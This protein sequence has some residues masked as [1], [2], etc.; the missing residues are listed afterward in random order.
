MLQKQV[1]TN[2]AVDTA[3]VT[4]TAQKED[5]ATILRNLRIATKN[6]INRVTTLETELKRVDSTQ[7]SI[8]KMLKVISE[9]SETLNLEVED[10]GKYSIYA[11]IENNKKIASFILPNPKKA[12]VAKEE[13]NLPD[14]LTE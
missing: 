9:N 14:W 8:K 10:K 13:E 1:T 12:A 6:L 4:P 7:F 5:P 11:L 2:P 3:T